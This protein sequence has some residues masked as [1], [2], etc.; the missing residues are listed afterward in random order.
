[1][2]KVLIIKRQDQMEIEAKEKANWVKSILTSIGLPTDDWS[3]NLSMDDLRRI[4]AE[5]K[6]LDIDILDDTAGGIEI[7]YQGELI[8]EFRKP[9]FILK[10]NPREKDPRNRYYLEMHLNCRSV[11]DEQNKSQEDE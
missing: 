9:N 6:S 11:F 1:M 4:R 8:A 2:S 3:E 5:L 7:Y 10:E